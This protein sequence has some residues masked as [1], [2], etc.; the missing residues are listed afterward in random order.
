MGVPV[1]RT[2]TGGYEDTK[3][4]CTGVTYGDTEALAKELTAFFSGDKKFKEKADAALENRQRF[5]AEYMVKKYI[6][7]YDEIDKAKET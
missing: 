6:N 5:S 7:I 3:D 1:I 2:K 4:Y